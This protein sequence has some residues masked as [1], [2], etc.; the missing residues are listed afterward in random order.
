MKDS[1]CMHRHLNP[2]FIFIGIYSLLCTRYF[3]TDNI[4]QIETLTHDTVPNALSP[5]HPIH[6]DILW[7]P[8]CTPLNNIRCHNTKRRRRRRCAQTFPAEQHLLSPQIE[9]IMHF[10]PK[11]IICT[12]ISS[13]PFIIGFQR[14]CVCA[15]ARI[16]IHFTPILEHMQCHAVWPKRQ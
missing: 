2:I 15:W 10:T 7:I 3:Q 13:G 6:V 8:W 5:L 1:G 14:F 16:C 12:G 4:D 11:V 9:S